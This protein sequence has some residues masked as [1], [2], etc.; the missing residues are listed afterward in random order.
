MTFKI[1]IKRLEQKDIEVLKT[2]PTDKSFVPQ[3]DR[4]FEKKEDAVKWA[5]NHST[6]YIVRD[7]TE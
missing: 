6:T 1:Y 4:V 2:L 3:D 5:Y 7:E